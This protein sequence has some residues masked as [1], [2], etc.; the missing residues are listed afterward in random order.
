MP[1]KSKNLLIRN[2]WILVINHKIIFNSFIKRHVND[3]S[4]LWMFISRATNH[5]VKRFHGERSRALLND[6]TLKFKDMLP[7]S[8]NTIIYVNNI[9]ILKVEFYKYFYGLSAPKLKAVLAK[10]VLMYILRICRVKSLP[11]LKTVQ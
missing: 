9:P 10:R 6:E 1:Q 7:K 8:N 5:N 4:L 11:N 2:R 3:C